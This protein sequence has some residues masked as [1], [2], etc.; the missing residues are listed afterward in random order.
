M[1]T[2]AKSK[3]SSSIPAIAAI[4]MAVATCSTHQS[5][6][7]A[8]FQSPL[9]PLISITEIGGKMALDIH[10]MNPDAVWRQEF[11]SAA[12]SR[13]SE[14]LITAIILPSFFFFFF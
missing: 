12:T 8:N 1:V 9:F 4:A 2:S 11:I 3:T 13:D 5:P 7:G 6:A 14:G 10:T